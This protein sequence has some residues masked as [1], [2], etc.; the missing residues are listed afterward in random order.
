MNYTL[1]SVICWLTSLA[2]AN[3]ER[4]EA[5]PDKL[6]VERV[7]ELLKSDADAAL[8][9]AAELEKFTFLDPVDLTH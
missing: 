8:K 1:Q 3:A 9:L 7:R 6:T 2:S 5:L 4:A